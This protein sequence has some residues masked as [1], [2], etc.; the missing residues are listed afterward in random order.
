[1]CV[2]AQTTEGG[3][4]GPVLRGPT[5]PLRARGRGQRQSVGEYPH[6]WWMPGVWARAI[7]VIAACIGLYIGLFV[8]R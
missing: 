4:L 5:R 8:R 1:M 3:L 7:G 6:V 2:A